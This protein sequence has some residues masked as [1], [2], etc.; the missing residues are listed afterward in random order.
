MSTWICEKGHVVPRDDD[1][2]TAC[3]TLTGGLPP[4]ICGARM[5]MRVS[6]LTTISEERDQLRAAIAAHQ[7]ASEGWEPDSVGPDDERLWSMVDNADHPEVYERHEATKEEINRAADE[8][9]W[10]RQRMLERAVDLTCA[11]AAISAPPPGVEFDA[12]PR[13]VVVW[14]GRHKSASSRPLWWPSGAQSMWLDSTIEAKGIE[15]PE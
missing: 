3:S 4:K 11:A 6:E 2:L 15:V 1:C 13:V 5:V 7:A 9:A 8:R 12:V 10:L 14:V